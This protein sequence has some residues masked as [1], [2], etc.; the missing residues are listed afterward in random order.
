MARTCKDCGANLSSYNQGLLCWPCQ[1]KKKEL[2]QEQIGDTPNYTVDNL[3]IILG[4][5]NPESVKRL[6]RKGK[7]PGRVPGIR[8][9]LY[10]RD[11][12][13]LWIKE[14]HQQLPNAA[15]IEESARV[16]TPHKQKIESLSKFIELPDNC[17]TA[18]MQ[19]NSRSPSAPDN[20]V[21]ETLQ[22]KSPP[23]EQNEKPSVDTN[24]QPG[25]MIAEENKHEPL[26]KDA[27]P[28]PTTMQSSDSEP[29]SKASKESMPLSPE[30]K[31]LICLAPPDGI[32]VVVLESWGIPDKK[33]ADILFHWRKLHRE[34]S[35]QMCQAFHTLEDNLKNQ[36][37]P[38]RRAE[39]YLNAELHARK[40]N[41]DDALSDLERSRKYRIWERPENLKAFFKESEELMK[42]ML[43]ARQK[44][45]KKIEN[46][47]KELQ[48]NVLTSLATKKYDNLLKMEE[49]P[50]FE[51]LQT[52]CYDVYNFFWDLKRNLETAQ[53]LESDTN[54]SEIDKTTDNSKR[55]ELLKLQ[56]D[57]ITS[58]KQLRK[59][60]DYTLKNKLYSKEWCPDCYHDTTIEANP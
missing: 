39:L 60:I 59:A 21:S 4:L 55:K 5:K 57:T 28:V 35:H 19:E 41:I 33:A 32:N 50:L 8:Q 17:R 16:E 42:P 14:G 49:N 52:H 34:G 30:E 9:Y 46:L 15:M 3:R 53:Y 56:K 6:G 26:S 29:L 37:I 23:D 45:L 31:S 20:N 48:D 2:L 36:K 22:I 44:H 27:E 18:S 13:D 54:T 1:K 40:F 11:K 51:S 47:L 38:F 10:R 25:P 7:I 24:T 58:I 43:E 12:V